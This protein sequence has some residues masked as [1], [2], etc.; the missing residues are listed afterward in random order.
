VTSSFFCNFPEDVVRD[1]ELPNAP[2]FSLNYLLRYDFA[3]LGGE[4]ALQT[5]GVYYD[6][7]YLEVTNGLSSLQ[8]AYGVANVS[9]TWSGPGDRLELQL[10][11]KNVLDEEYRTYTLNLGVL[12]TTSVFAPPATWGVRVGVN[13]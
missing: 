9:A 7:Q 3:A 2:R 13:W 8:P 6:D 10:C 5:D 1:A 12:G 11:G 4:V